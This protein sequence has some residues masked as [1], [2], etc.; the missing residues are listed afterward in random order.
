MER[1]GDGRRVEGKKKVFLTSVACLAKKGRKRDRVSCKKKCTTL[2]VGTN[3]QKDLHFG[4]DELRNKQKKPSFSVCGKRQQTFF[5]LSFT[6]KVDALEKK[7]FF[8]HHLAAAAAA[9]AM[10]DVCVCVCVRLDEMR[11]RPRGVGGGG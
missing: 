4:N 5:F 11:D 1:S 10:S 2:C 6:A 9:A 3:K 7:K 8:F